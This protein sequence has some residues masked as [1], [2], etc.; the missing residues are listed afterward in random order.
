MGSKDKR[1]ER[2]LHRKV[3]KAKNSQKRKTGNSLEQTLTRSQQTIRSADM[4]G[5]GDLYF[6]P[7][8]TAL[9]T[10]DRAELGA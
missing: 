7:S 3:L 9:Y 1:I 2:E 6:K 5:N 8:P 10:V 4:S